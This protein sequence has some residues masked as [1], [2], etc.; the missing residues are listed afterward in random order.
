MGTALERCDTV[1]AGRLPYSWLLAPDLAYDDGTQRVVAL[2][3][4]CGTG[5]TLDG[6]DE[7]PCEIEC[8]A[9][10]SQDPAGTYEYSCTGA[11]LTEPAPQC[12]GK[13]TAI[14]R[15]LPLSCP[16]SGIGQTLWSDQVIYGACRSLRGGHVRPDTGPR[17]LH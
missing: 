14:A 15:Q 5:G 4:P 17:D 16:A 10:Q 2:D 6:A 1:A 3:C 7:G 11:D 13:S 9:G 12:E 8:V